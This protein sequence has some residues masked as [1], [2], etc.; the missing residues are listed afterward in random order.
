MRSRGRGL[1]ALAPDQRPDGEGLVRLARRQ[2]DGG[3]EFGEGGGRDGGGHG[4]RLLMA[5]PWAGPGR[6]QG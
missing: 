4:V 1:A 5:R 3:E 2:G 6:V